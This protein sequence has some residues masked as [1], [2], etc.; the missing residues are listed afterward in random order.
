VTIRS[1]LTLWYSGILGAAL[2]AMGLLAYYE[3]VVEP[4]SRPVEQE[5]WLEEEEEDFGEV[6]GLV[7]WCGVPAAV[8]GMLGGWWLTR[9]ALA[10]VAALTAAAARINEAS[11]AEQLP[12]T[13]NGDELDRLTGTFN[14]MTERLHQSFQRIREFTLHASHELKTPLT[15]LHAEMETALLGDEVSEPQRDRLLSQID[16]IQRLTRIV[17]SLTF[18]TKADAGLVRMRLDRIALDELVHEGVACAEL[19]AAPCGVATRLEACDAIQIHGDRHRLR[20]LLLNLVDNAVKYS[21]AGGQVTMS[22]LRS[23]DSAVFNIAN[24]GPGIP[25]ERL[26]RVFDRFYRGDESHNNKVDGCGLGLSIVQWIVDAHRGS[27]QVESEPGE[28]TR[29]TV[30]LPIAAGEEQERK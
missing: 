14:A 12:R 20:Q 28:L 16:E 7:L 23:G 30:R 29:F 8:F 18:L 3:F 24:T 15:V 27:V 11:L 6:I 26:S 2:L 4:R 17:D 9:N 25:P 1:R 21:A 13:G 5:D 22:L 10:P 19:L